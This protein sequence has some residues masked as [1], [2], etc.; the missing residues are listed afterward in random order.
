VT[1]DRQRLRSTCCALVVL[2]CGPSVPV[3][4]GDT[5]VMDDGADDD[6]TFG[7]SQP[8]P[9][10][11]TSLTSGDS[12]G[13]DVSTAGPSE[14]GDAITSDDDEGDDR[15]FIP[16]PDGGG[17]NECDLWI[18]DC[19]AG[20]KC[21]PWAN[22]GGNE[23][24]ATRCTPLADDPHAPGEPC[25]V[26][27]NGVSGIDDCEAHAMCWYVDPDTSM[28]ECV[29]MCSGSEANPICESTCEYCRLTSAGVLLLCFPYCDPLVQDCGAGEGC[30][31]AGDDFACAPHVGL[32]QG[33][34]G[35]E[36]EFLNVCDPGLACLEGARVPGCEG[37]VGCCA[38]FCDVL[39]ADP[40]PPLLEGTSCV[41][42][43]DEGEQ[44]PCGSSIVGICALPE[45][46]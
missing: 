4:G 22:D 34:I 35:D 32:K 12:T 11:P 21:M 29:A 9:S 43:F 44:P 39:A 28:G 16:H 36:C 3:D 46:G 37:A 40:C 27:G 13:N 26:E 8:D 2:A 5:G 38:P 23:W 1:T 20:F 42:W 15:G 6:D 24:N 33:A 30:Y 19:P 17:T 10:A 31:P 25:T 7:G 45:G 14:T 18:D 41:P